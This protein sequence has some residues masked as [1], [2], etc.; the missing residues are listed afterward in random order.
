MFVLPDPF[1]PSHNLASHISR[2]SLTRLFAVSTIALAKLQAGAPLGAVFGPFEGLGGVSGLGLSAREGGRKGQG[3]REGK[4]AEGEFGV[5]I[6]GSERERFRARERERERAANGALE[7]A[8]N[9]MDAVDVEAEKEKD[10]VIASSA[11]VYTDADADADADGARRVGETGTVADVGRAGG[12]S[13][14]QSRSRSRSGSR[15]ASPIPVGSASPL[16]ARSASRMPVE[17]MVV[18]AAGGGSMLRG[19]H[20]SARLGARLEEGMDVFVI[21]PVAPSIL[22]QRAKTIGKVTYVVKSTYGAQYRVQC[23]GSTQY[24]TDSAGSDLDLVVIDPERPAG[25]SPDVNLNSLPPVYN[26]RK[27]GRALQRAGFVSV[28]CIPGA[29]VPIVK[30]KDPRTNIHCDIN[31]ND[32][33]GVKNTELIARYIELLPVLRP[34]LSAIKKWAGVHGL[35]NP[36]GRQGAVSFSSYAL[37]VMSIAFFQMKGLLPNL[38]DEE[39]MSRRER[40]FWLRTKKHGMRVKCDVRWRKDVLTWE[41]P[42]EV[43]LAEALAEWFYYWGHEHRYGDDLVS[44]RHGGLIA[45]QHPYKGKAITGAPVPFSG[46]VKAEGH[47]PKQSVTSLSTADGKV[48]NTTVEADGEGGQVEVPLVE[49]L[50][51]LEVKLVDDLQEAES[52]QIAHEDAADMAS[53]AIPTETTP[54]HDSDTPTQDNVHPIAATLLSELKK[55]QEV[56]KDS[57]TEEVKK[58]STTEE[59]QLL[60]GASNVVEQDVALTVT[61]DDDI[62]QSEAGESILSRD[63]EQ[64]PNWS[65][66]PLCVRDPFIA[67]KNV[68]SAIRISTIERFR[69]DC[70]RVYMLL[71][72]GGTWSDVMP[73]ESSVVESDEEDASLWD[74]ILGARGKKGAGR[75]MGMRGGGRGKKGRGGGVRDNGDRPARKETGQGQSHLP[76][77]EG[78]AGPSTS[79]V[80]VAKK[81]VERP[82]VGPSNDPTA[83]S[84][85]KSSQGQS[86]L[87]TKEGEPVP[88]TSTVPF[89][90]QPVEQPTAGPSTDP[91]TRSP[92]KSSE[93]STAT[94]IKG[95]TK[96]G[97]ERE[98]V[99]SEATALLEKSLAGI[100]AQ[101]D[102]QPSSSA[103]PSRKPQFPKRADKAKAK[104]VDVQQATKQ[105]TAT[106]RPSGQDLP[107]V[108]DVHLP[109]STARDAPSTN[110][111]LQPSSSAG[112]SRMPKFPTHADKAKAKAVDVQQDTPAPRPSGQ[113]LPS[114]VQDV[115]LPDPSS[116]D[117]SSTNPNQLPPKAPR[118]TRAERKARREAEKA[119]VIVASEVASTSQEHSTAQETLHPDPSTDQP[120]KKKQLPGGEKKAKREE[121]KTDVVLA[122]EVGGTD[123]QG[124]RS[125]S[126]PPR[127]KNKKKKKAATDGVLVGE[128]PEISQAPNAQ[129]S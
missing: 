50:P 38:Q 95:Q 35:N 105:D 126:V 21:T 79:T 52:P 77:K 80:Q 68:T 115:P 36:S 34:L 104:T 76:V 117:A 78:E 14:A 10:G 64:Q 120:S 23:F 63:D 89:A 101:R 26:I 13:R 87:P 129:A 100:R 43:E 122:S 118:W 40:V 49:I 69:A 116:R 19:F 30:F 90:K 92:P 71:S 85:P 107:S 98:V 127:K 3:E 27:L 86:G 111:L 97:K 22:E 54:A 57:T 32:R 17:S 112:P 12:M 114:T 66:A 4:R 9:A 113:D 28:E 47:E 124:S 108:Q 1:V 16:P 110:Q 51:D 109:D 103:G 45:R 24:G 88:S 59:V 81:P 93:L 70:Q 61:A 102:G 91:S 62:A 11:G 119:T 29:T 6:R 46:E 41:P 60:A 94:D 31:I 20:T 65:A 72:L 18:A 73:T 56:E 53:N 83:P 96:K 75:G 25:F 33:L 84:P 128:R 8:S 74:E 2:A 7:G 44:I 67:Q 42:R 82:A 123:E 125:S 48:E 5:R 58:D 99:R 55:S 106:P 39:G 37:T 15:V 121:K